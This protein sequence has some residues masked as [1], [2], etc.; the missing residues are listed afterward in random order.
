MPSPFGVPRPPSPPRPDRSR[1]PGQTADQPKPWPMNPAHLRASSVRG[2]APPHSQGPI[3]R[4]RP[5][6]RPRTPPR[7]GLPIA[8]DRTAAEEVS[9]AASSVMPMVEEEEVDDHSFLPVIAQIRERTNIFRNCG[10]CES[11]S[12]MQ[13]SLLS[14]QQEKEEIAKTTNLLVHLDDDSKSRL[15]LSLIHI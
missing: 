7:R 14:T 9:R 15:D 8:C 6:S 5:S 3:G 11:L 4:R 2:R 1:T 13:L 10:P 12:R